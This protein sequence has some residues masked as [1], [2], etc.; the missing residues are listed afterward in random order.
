MALAGEI[1]SFPQ[2][3]NFAADRGGP[4]TMRTGKP[5]PMDLK[6]ANANTVQFH[7]ENAANRPN[8]PGID[9][10]DQPTEQKSHEARPLPQLRIIKV[11]T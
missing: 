4:S 10:P 2:A 8:G 5:D 3:L 1:M 9:A 6:A 11:T 7:P